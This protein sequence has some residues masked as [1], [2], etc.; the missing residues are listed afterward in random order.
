M[1]GTI[2]AALPDAENRLLNDEKEQ[3]EHY[4]IVDLMR[5]DLAM[6]ASDIQVTKFRY[7]DRIATQKG[8]ICKQVPKFVVNLMKNGNKYWSF[9]CGFTAGRID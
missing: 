4:T 8:E 6:V 9:A 5:N 7:V 3:R 1:K 2:N